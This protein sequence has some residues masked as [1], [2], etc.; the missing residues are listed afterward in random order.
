MFKLVMKSV[1]RKPQRFKAAYFVLG[2]TA[3]PYGYCPE[4]GIQMA[5]GKY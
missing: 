1:K 5:V 3:E 4:E 2:N